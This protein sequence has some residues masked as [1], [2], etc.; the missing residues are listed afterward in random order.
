MMHQSFRWDSKY[1]VEQRFTTLEASLIAAGIDPK[2]AVPYI[3]PL[4][5]LP[6]GDRYPIPSIPPDQQRKRTPRYFSRVG[7]RGCKGAAT[8]HCDR[9]LAL[10]GSL[11]ARIDSAAG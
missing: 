9:R 11:D 4:L 7:I 3:A 8:G 2:E 10:G 5:D 6:L 1:S